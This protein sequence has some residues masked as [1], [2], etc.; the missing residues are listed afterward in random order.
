VGDREVRRAAVGE[1]GTALR[2]LVDAAV[3]TEVS[4]SE[5]A[6]ATGL[7]RE[8]TARLRAESR[9]LHEIASVDDPEIGERWYSPVYGPGNPVAPPMVASQTPDGRAEGRVTLGK[10][11]E[12]P[13]GL[14]HG[15]VVA[16]LLDHVLARSVRAAGYGGLTA[17]LTVT[18]RRPVRL[19]VSL[20]VVAEVGENDGRR[21]TARARMVAEADPETTLAEAEGLFVALSPEQAD[22]VF[23]PTGRTI[24]AWT[25]RK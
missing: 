18:Y 8:L 2:E 11:H 21:T 10:P 6:E 20:L 19:G 15:G 12:G 13:P 16:T 22:G 5:L 4:L 3:R 23:A 14:V 1:L 25:S 17:T 7:A 9:E 24:R